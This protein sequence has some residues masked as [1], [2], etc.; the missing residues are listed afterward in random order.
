VFRLWDRFLNAQ[1][2]MLPANSPGGNCPPA[3]SLAALSALVP[4]SRPGSMEEEVFQTACDNLIS[5]ELPRRNWNL[6]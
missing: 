4:E 1:P 2:N 6:R 5:V 3:R